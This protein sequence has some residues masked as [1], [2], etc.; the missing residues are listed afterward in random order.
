[1]TVDDRLSSLPDGATLITWSVESIP[2]IGPLAP[3]AGFALSQAIK[4]L[5]TNLAGAADIKSLARR[6]L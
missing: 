5:S 6:A 3:V 2:R 1:M 4:R